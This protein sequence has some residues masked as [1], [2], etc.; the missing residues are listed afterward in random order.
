MKRDRAEVEEEATE[1]G[2]W[3]DLARPEWFPDGRGTM[4]VV[5][6]RVMRSPA[7]ELVPPLILDVDKVRAVFLFGDVRYFDTSQLRFEIV[8]DTEWKIVG[9]TEERQTGRGSFLLLLAAFDVGDAPGNEPEVRMDLASVAG[10][11]V[12]VCGRNAAYEQVFENVVSIH[13]PRASGFS[14]VLENPLSIRPPALLAR[15]A[16]LERAALGL[17]VADPADA[18]RLNLA[19]RWVIQAVYDSGADAYIKYWVALETLAMPDTTNVRPIVEA[20]GRVYGIS[21]SEARTRFMVG[22]LQS[23]RSRIVHRGHIPAVHSFLLDYLDA[24]FYDVLSEKL[25][26][27]GEKR[28][29]ALLAVP[30]FDLPGLLGSP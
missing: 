21:P 24:L 27:A 10:L 23:F 12:A 7:G 13:E 14:Q 25:G 16:A 29:G 28:A 19:F 3:A 6:Y 8:T 20:L 2:G 11:I 15:R 9:E 30:E 5:G 26:F 22:R 1:S 4:W 17:S 18:E